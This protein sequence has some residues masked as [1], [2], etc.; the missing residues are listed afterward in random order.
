VLLF[1]LKLQKSDLRT[2]DS[3]DSQGRN[4]EEGVGAEDNE[5][6]V[7]NELSEERAIEILQACHKK[8]ASLVSRMSKNLIEFKKG[9]LDIEE[10]IVKLLGV[11]AVIR[12]LRNCD[13][14][15]S[16]VVKGKTTV[17]L[18]VRQK[19]LTSILDSLFEGEHSIWQLERNTPDI[20][21]TDD[22]IKLKGLM[23]WLIWDCDA[24]FNTQEKFGESKEAKVKRIIFNSWVLTAGQLLDKDNKIMEQAMESIGPLCKDD[25]SWL[26]SL[27]RFNNKLAEIIERREVS[28]T[29][30][31]AKEGDIA[32]HA[33]L[34]HLP[35]RL[36][37]SSSYGDFVAMQTHDSKKPTIKFMKDK[38]NII[39]SETFFETFR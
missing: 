38:V 22:M 17:P 35:L 1:H 9:N 3:V 30:K 5:I 6:E 15:Q 32:F 4:E 18:D 33:T 21:L 37:D 36:V 39:P 25:L 34:S 8:M 14:T 26:K 13:N 24:T 31:R 29:V 16:W 27:C 19:L 12:E 7:D 2:Y 20:L 11:L 28:E 23:I 10:V